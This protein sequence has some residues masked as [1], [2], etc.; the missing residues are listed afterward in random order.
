[1]GK[2]SGPLAYDFL[3]DSTHDGKALRG[4]T[5]LD[6]FTRECLAIVVGRTLT[7]DEVLV[8]LTDLF[9]TRG[10]SGAPDLG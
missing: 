8:T 3:T 10:V 7:A 6:E 2:Q 1:M 9:I 4:L 5:I